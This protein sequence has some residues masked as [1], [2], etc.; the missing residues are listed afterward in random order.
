MAGERLT[1]SEL[2]NKHRKQFESFW[3]AYPRKVAPAEAEKTF[4]EMVEYRG[5]DPVHVINAA[6]NYALSGPDLQY[7]PA[8]HSWLK[9]GR[10]DDADLFTDE[11]AAQR[12]WLVQQ[13][14]TANVKAVENRYHVTMPKSYPP[15]DIA[16]EDIPFWYREKCREWITEIYKE[17]VEK[18]QTGSQPT[19]SAPSSPSSEPCSTT[20]Q[21]SLAI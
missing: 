15:E 12:N 10:Y 8:P 9:Q 2:R 13:W 5:L 16:K 18:C 17:K 7:V 1:P 3:A 4:A 20:Q 21:E 11:Q 6:R 19:T 14:K